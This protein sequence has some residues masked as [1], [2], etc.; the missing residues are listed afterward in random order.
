MWALGDLLMA[1]PILTSLKAKWP[2]CEITWATDTNYAEVLRG[3]PYIDYLFEVDSGPW[4]RLFRRGNIAKFWRKSMRM[5]RDLA[6][7]NF[8]IVI[9]LVP[10][11]WWTVFFLTAP[12]KIGLYPEQKSTWTRRWYTHAIIRV[13][14]KEHATEHYLN[15]VR[16]LECPVDN[17]KLSIG[18][19]PSE[20]SFLDRFFTTKKLDPD[21][22][23]IVLSPFGS[24]S[25]RNWEPERCAEISNWLA[26]SYCVNVV[27]IS[28]PKY[29]DDASEIVKLS[30]NS[31]VINAGDT[32]IRDAIA[33]MRR[34]ELII[35][36]DSGPMHIAAA[37][38]KPFVALF[39]PGIPQ[40]WFPMDSNGT[41]VVKPLECSPCQS[42][43]CKHQ[44]FRQ[45]MKLITVDEI[46]DVLRRR[47]SESGIVTIIGTSSSTF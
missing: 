39:G 11:K 7:M 13:N 29:R 27:V 9:N 34:S 17:F 46:K 35:T 5:Q 12:I 42:P 19:T 15:A 38:G 25:N 44:V 41:L 21:S 1:T 4:T 2:D 3:N 24:F 43:T 33:L 32:T 28:S 16:A 10:D 18:V 40:R 8:D 45:C 30:N 6:E 20:K 36:V 47:L 14:D 23:L 37:L 31:N 22:K 26:E